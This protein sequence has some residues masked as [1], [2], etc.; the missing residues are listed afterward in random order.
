M[1]GTHNDTVNVLIV[2]S[3]E[4]ARNAIA[5]VVSSQGYNCMMADNAD[6]ARLW[7]K[8][9]Q[10]SLIIAN[11]QIDKISGF[12]F[13]RA[14]KQDNPHAE[15]PVIF[16]SDSKAHDVVQQ[17]RDAGGIFFLSRPIDPDVLLEL[18]DKALWMP[19]LIRRHVETPT[20]KTEVKAPYSLN[21]A[22]TRTD[23]FSNF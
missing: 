14:V 22:I 2:D 12:E 11:T 16:V 20:H 19:H 10:P 3:N 7:S 18:V 23:A 6:S 4:T 8:R 9:N 5:K 21:P 13:C 17:S 15:I 1:S